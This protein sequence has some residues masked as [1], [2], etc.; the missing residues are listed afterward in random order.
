MQLWKDKAI[1]ESN[2]AAEALAGAKAYVGQL[3]ATGVLPMT[4]GFAD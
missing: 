3:R 4:W 1:D 2:V